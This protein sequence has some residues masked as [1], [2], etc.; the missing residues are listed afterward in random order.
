MKE[1]GVTK[2]DLLIVLKDFRY[3]EPP[4]KVEL[5]R[6]EKEAEHALAAFLRNCKEYQRLSKLVKSASN[7]TERFRKSRKDTFARELRNCRNMI[8]M[9]GT[10]SA[11]IKAV[12]QF[13]EKYQ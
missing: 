1:S 6:A 10:T 9:Q 7:A 12:R 8:Y 4:K 3:Y 11:T 5:E 2:N 13:V